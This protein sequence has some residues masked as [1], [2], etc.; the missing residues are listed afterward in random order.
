[1]IAG[2]LERGTGLRPARGKVTP[3][4]KGRV[5]AGSDLAGAGRTAREKPSRLRRRRFPAILRGT[6][7]SREPML[8]RIETG[9]QDAAL[10]KWLD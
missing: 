5:R 2:G 7:R 8:L 10:A 9:A 1:M 4:G 6:N 3:T